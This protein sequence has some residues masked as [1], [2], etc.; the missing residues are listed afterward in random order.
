VPVCEEC[1]APCAEQPC[2][3][4]PK[5]CWKE[6]RVRCQQK[7]DF[8]R[9]LFHRRMGCEPSCEGGDSGGSCGSCDSCGSGH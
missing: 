3:K 7:N 9:R 8:M 6:C 1:P 4:A 2:C 5:Q